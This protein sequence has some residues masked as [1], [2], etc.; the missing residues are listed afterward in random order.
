MFM[1][2]YADAHYDFGRRFVEF[3]RLGFWLSCRNQGL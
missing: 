2:V 3:S 1:Y